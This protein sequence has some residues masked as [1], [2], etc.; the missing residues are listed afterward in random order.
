MGCGAWHGDRARVVASTQQ[1]AHPGAAVGAARKQREK[2]GRIHRTSYC[3]ASE[4]DLN[5]TLS[6]RADAIP[7]LL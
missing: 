2:Q 3:R 5:N 7:P 4:R 1:P 6:C